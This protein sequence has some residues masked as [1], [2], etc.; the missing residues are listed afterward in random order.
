MINFCKDC[1]TELV[2]Y[3]CVWPDGSVR[4]SRCHN[5]KVKKLDKQIEKKPKVMGW[6]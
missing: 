3:E 1:K 5:K 4:C 6:I 2:L